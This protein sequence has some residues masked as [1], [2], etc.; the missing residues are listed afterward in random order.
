MHKIR[1]EEMYILSLPFFLF[2][3]EIAKTKNVSIAAKKLNYSQS[4]LSHALN[5]AENELGFKLFTRDKNGLHLTAQS[6]QIQIGRASC[7]ERV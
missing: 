1:K 3:V 5:R 2:F 7:R 4:G 6:R